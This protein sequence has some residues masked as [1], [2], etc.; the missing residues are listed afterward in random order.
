MLDRR[1]LV[2]NRSWLPITTTSV[3]RAIVLMA[4]GAA[5]AVHPHTFEVASWHAWIE[6]GPTEVAQ[7]R[8]IG[9]T[10]P[11]PDVIVLRAFNGNADRPVAFTRRNVHRRDGYRCVYCGHSP[12][13]SSL[14]IDH[15]LPRSRGGQTTWENCVTACMPCN[16]RK[17]DHELRVA[18]L[19]LR[20]EPTAPR[21]PGGLDPRSL[22]ERPAWHQF[23]PARALAAAL[24]E[25]SA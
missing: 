12:G 9:F 4:R 24:S 22:R 25:T 17:A 10:F 21:W 6:R 5:G 16:G 11:V 14:T 15:V 1:T 18:G 13:L 3:R 19:T 2:L 20:R 7:L 23:I 8:G